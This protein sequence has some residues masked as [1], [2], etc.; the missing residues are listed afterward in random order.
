MCLL[1]TY[2]SDDLLG[3]A[4][5]DRHLGSLAIYYLLFSPGP[6]PSTDS[7]MSAVSGGE[8]EKGQSK[9]PSAPHNGSSMNRS[10]NWVVGQF[11][12][13]AVIPQGGIA[14]WRR[15]AASTSMNQSM[16]R[17]RSRLQG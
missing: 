9:I 1:G 4:E 10:L 7:T 2:T 11:D 17:C 5:S 8:R 15:K 14:K 13:V 12:V 6:V 16:G 3:P